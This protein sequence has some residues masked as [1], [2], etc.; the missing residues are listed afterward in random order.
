MRIA[1]VGGGPAGLY[2]AL[3][4]K[5]RDPGHDI[6]VF[7]RNAAGS[8]Q[9][10][11]V[12]FGRD[13]LKELHRSD[14]ESAR[15]ID[16]AAFSQFDQVVDIHGK[17]VLYPGGGGYGISRPR[18]L[19]ILAGRAQGLGVHIEFGHEVMAASQLPA[20]DLIVACDGVNSRMRLEAGGFQADVRLGGNKYLWLGTTKMFESF[21]YAFV[22]TD[23]GWV[24]AYAYGI[25]AGVSTF[26]VECSPETWAALGFGAL[27]LPDNISLLE[28]LFERHLDDHRLL[29]QVQGGASAGWLNF[30]TVTSQRW[31]D[32]NIVLAGDAAH[33]THFTTGSGT[34]LAIED[35][36]ALA[37]SLQRHGDQDLALQSYERQRKAA[38]LR[39]Q[40]DARFSARWF[41]NI[42]RY[43]DL[44]PRE[45]SALLHGRRSP[46]LPHLPPRLYYRLHQATEEVA[47]LGELRRR[48]VPRAKA[49][50]S[51]HRPARPG[52]GSGVRDHAKR[53]N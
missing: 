47:V 49:I 45:F 52:N 37:G 3:L 17:Q 12:T 20:A 6:T 43:A 13:L 30:R 40:S 25:G 34:T 31:H 9:G 32:G 33:T 48:V 2:F 28:K 50:Y 22:H 21:T 51:Q 18:L 41:E 4:M 15:E 8:T 38:L 24:W 16:Q 46:L 36:I 10:W 35:A 23:G 53:W 5:L 26:I 42:S 19:D 29:G 14:P 44:E 7:E 27:S 39:Q 1:C 11:G